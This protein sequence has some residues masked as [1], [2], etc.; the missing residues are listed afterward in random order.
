MLHL[1][2]RAAIVAGESKN[3]REATRL[4]PGPKPIP[5]EEHRR[6]RV[7]INLTDAELTAL[8]EAAGTEKHTSFARRI[9]LQYLARRRK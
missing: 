8:R 3:K 2:D 1:L 5:V 6:N 7:M 4:A 9:L